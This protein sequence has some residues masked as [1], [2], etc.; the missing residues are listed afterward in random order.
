APVAELADLTMRSAR[1]GKQIILGKPMAM[2]V[3]EA[4]R[5]IA[6]VEAAGVSCIAL[7]GMMRLREAGLKA[8]IDQGEIGDLLLIHQTSRWSI[9]EDWIGSGTPGWFADPR[10]VPGGAFID[11]GIY[12][13][14]LF[15]WLSG[16]AA[17]EVAA[18]TSNL[19]HKELPVE[20]W[21]MA[22]FT[23]A[24]GVVA[25]LEASWTITAP[26]KTGPS[27]K[28]N[29]VVRLEVVGSRGEIMDQYF[30]VPG[31]AVLAA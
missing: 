23:F 8:R 1:A 12:W 24:N 29:G 25:T 5:M 6:A 26:R 3:D 27:P 16:S 7:Q 11:E 17:I 18:R 22:T 20:D 28:Q 2:S 9:A 15:R 4:D 13:V 21:G 31:R 19:V 10:Q 14:D 30:R